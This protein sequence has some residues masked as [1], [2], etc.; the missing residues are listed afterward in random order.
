MLF[1]QAGD[2]RPPYHAYSYMAA[3]GLL[4]PSE[5]GSARRHAAAATLFALRAH[6]AAGACGLRVRAG[7]HSGPVT[8]GL[9]G[10]LRA[11]FCLFGDTVNTAS[12]LE[13]AGVSGCVQASR[14]T[15]RLAGL[16]DALSP[17]ERRLQLKGKAGALDACLLRADA[18]EAAQADAALQAQL[19]LY[20]DGGGDE[21]PPP[22]S[23]ALQ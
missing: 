6:A 1:A 5:A 2:S 21:P 18:P 11:R 22:T 12:R 10:R 23:D 9:V 7:V 19:A 13:A 20:D 17:Q 8:S 15:W 3:A 4:S 14:S 16:P